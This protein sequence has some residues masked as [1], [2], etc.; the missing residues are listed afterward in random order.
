VRI[1]FERLFR[2]PDWIP[3]RVLKKESFRKKVPDGILDDFDLR[4]IIEVERTLKNKAYYERVLKNT[5]EKDYR[6]DTILYIMERE[7]DKQ[8]LMKQAKAWEPIFFITMEELVQMR[9]GVAILNAEGRDIDLPRVHQGGALFN[10]AGEGEFVPPDDG[11][12]E[13]REEDRK[14][15]QWKREQ[16]KLRNEQKKKKTKEK[17]FKDLAELPKVA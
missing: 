15:E 17:K 4:L 14:F 12:E 16:E 11:F 13:F 10:L 8:W 3:E 5:C 6:E 2:I 7:S 9:E 1:I